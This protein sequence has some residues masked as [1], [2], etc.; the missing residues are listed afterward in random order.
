MLYK[1]V[2]KIIR[3]LAAGSCLY[4]EHGLLRTRIRTD[5]LWLVSL[6]LNGPTGGLHTTTRVPRPQGVNDIEKWLFSAFINLPSWTIERGGGSFSLD[7]NLLTLSD[8][9]FSL[10]PTQTNWLV[11]VQTPTMPPVQAGSISKSISR[12]LLNS[13]PNPQN[14]LLYYSVSG[15]F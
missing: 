5:A 8:H 3:W 6:G 7:L 13:N 2:P 11:P 15:H 1:N 9:L 4:H 12:G 10:V 14:V